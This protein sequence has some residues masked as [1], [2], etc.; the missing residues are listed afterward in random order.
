MMVVFISTKICMHKTVC[1][2]TV[3]RFHDLWFRASVP[4]AVELYLQPKFCHVSLFWTMLEGILTSQHV[5]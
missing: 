1:K 2:L 4:A 5:S 3:V